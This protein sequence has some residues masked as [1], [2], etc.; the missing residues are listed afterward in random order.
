MEQKE[1]FQELKRL[2]A[3]GKIDADELEKR[4]RTFADIDDESSFAQ[5]KAKIAEKARFETGGGK[6]ASFIRPLRYVAAAVLTLLLI[7]GAFWYRQYVKVVPP[8]ISQEVQQAI[9]QSRESGREEAQISLLTENHQQQDKVANVLKQTY[10]ITD[11]DVV[12]QL[13]QARRVTTKNDKEFW[14]TLPDGSLIHLNYNTRVIYPEEFAGETR[15][16][17]LNGEAYFMVAKDNRHPFVVHTE[18]GNIQVSGTEFNVN[19][20]EDEGRTNVVLVTG[21]VSVKTDNGNE[22]S[23]HPGDMAILYPD[24]T[25]PVISQ[26][27]VEPYVAWNTGKFVFEDCTLEK[28][29]KVLSRWY[30]YRVQFDSEETRQLQFTGALD[31][32]ASVEPALRAI[33]KVMN[34]RIELDGKNE[35]II[36]DNSN[37]LIF[38]N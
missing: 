28:L 6:R 15:D 9:E 26:I 2:L 27:D 22:F 38:N 16:I 24:Q 32:Y 31:R 7:G 33:S 13:L 4:Y 20:R 5:L 10:K 11:N 17:I 23:L 29:M 12:E 25:S 14:L 30:G 21:K 37:S 34:L 1:D 36:I 35:Y 8:V 19:T 18:C 3:L